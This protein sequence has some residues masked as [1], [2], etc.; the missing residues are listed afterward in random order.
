MCREITDCGND[1]HSTT[2]PATCT[3]AT[4]ATPTGARDDMDTR[5]SQL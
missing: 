4:G 2:A 5:P 3:A 1:A